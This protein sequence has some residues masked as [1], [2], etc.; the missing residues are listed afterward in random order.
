MSNRQI[1]SQIADAID[2][3]EGPGAPR[4]NP[5][6]LRSWGSNPTSGG[7]AVF[8]TLEA[9]RAALERQIELNINR[10]LTLE[11]FFAGKPGVYAGY[12]PSADRNDPVKYARNVSQWTGIPLGVPIVRVMSGGTVTGPTAPTVPAPV[13][14]AGIGTGAGVQQTTPVQV[15]VQSGDGTDPVFSVT[16]T[17]FLDE[18]GT[19]AAIIVA[20]AVML[21]AAAYKS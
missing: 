10:G 6:N 19:L 15:P 1:I 4:N 7:F 8:P 13:V 12:A 11:E 18:P 14:Q 3:M 5:G 2:R 16:G 9:G 21:F 17:G 20:A